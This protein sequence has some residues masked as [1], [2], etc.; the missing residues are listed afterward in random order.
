MANI[1]AMGKQRTFKSGRIA[2]FFAVF[3][4]GFSGY[5]QELAIEEMSAPIFRDPIFDGAADP[6]VVYNSSTDEWW[7]F[8]TQRR[9]NVPSA[10]VAYCYGTNIGIAVSD[11]NGRS[12]Y[13]KGI[14]EGM[15][16]A[17]GVQTYWAPEIVE[18]DGVY[19]MFVTLIHGIYHDWGGERHIVHFTSTDLINWTF[20]SQLDLTSDRVIDPGV[21]QLPDGSWR[22]WYK[23]EAAG[24]I[25]R[26]AD[27]PDLLEWTTIPNSS[28]S[29]RSHEAPN[30][31]VWKNNYWLLTDTGQGLGIYRSSD[32]D[33]WESQG[34]IMDQF[35]QRTD[36][37][38]Y[39]QHPDVVILNDR[40][41][42]FYFVHAGRML[43]DKPNFEQSYNQTAPFEWKRTSLQ[44]AELEVIDG[45]LICDRDKYL[46]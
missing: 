3:L 32:G 25:T 12:F 27:S 23:D 43:F 11:N 15:D 2:F 4:V 7:I 28:A 24:S 9:A 21:I 36:D 13:Y 41:F 33:Q 14:C 34:L 37:G 17:D 42:I 38:W 30:V 35:G 1:I 18:S 10:G 40:A 22:L 20:I 5:G 29:D 39:G 26:A 31:M 16:I 45:K 6:S 46:K 8:Y 44:V 19:H